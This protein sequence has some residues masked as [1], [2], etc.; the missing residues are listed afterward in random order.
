MTASFPCKIDPAVGYDNSAS[1]AQAN[2]YDTLVTV[3]TDGIA[4]PSIAKSWKYDAKTKTYTLTL[5]KGVTFHSGN[6]LTAQDVVYSMN[7]LLIIGQGTSF[8]YK[9]WVSKITAPASDTV[10]IELTGDFGPFITT[11]SR[12]CVLDSKTVQ[13]NTKPE[14]PYDKNGDYGKDWLTTHEAGSGPYEIVEMKPAEYLYAKRFPKYWKG[15]ADKSPAAFK[16]IGTTEA[17]TVR[18]MMSRKDLEISDEWQSAESYEALKSLQG[19]KVVDFAAG[20][21]II[22]HLNSS[23]PPFDDVHMRKAFQ[24]CFDYQSARSLFPGSKSTNGPVGSAIPGFDADLPTFNKDLNKAKAEIALSRYKNTLGNYE[25]ELG[26]ASE[27]PSEE[28]LALLLQSNAQE[29]GLKVR[30][31]KAPWLTWLDRTTKATTTPHA[32]IRIQS[33]VPYPEAGAILGYFTTTSKGSPTN[34]HWFTEVVQAEIDKQVKDALSTMDTRQRFKKYK[35]VSKML[36]ESATDIW[37][38]ELPQRHAYQAAYLKW[39]A[40]ESATA[41][42]K[43]NTLIGLRVYFRDMRLVGQ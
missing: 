18:A 29:I 15:V 2:L 17:I 25:L 5:E 27:V 31:T 43:A 3:D 30:I 14:G 10:K 19:A 11:L 26:W 1:I 33:S 36:A 16:L 40:A 41:G 32:L 13:A 7:R 23:L 39:P 4:K 28:K 38:A 24:Y 22:V 8:I 21:L 37:A 6:P 34:P 9:N 20:G 12:L 42:G 35:A